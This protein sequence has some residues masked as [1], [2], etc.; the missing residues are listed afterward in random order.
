[1][2]IN[3][4]CST[5]QKYGDL[6]QRDNLRQLQTD[7][8]YSFD[9]AEYKVKIAEKDFYLLPSPHDNSK[10]EREVRNETGYLM[11]LSKQ[12]DVDAD[13]DDN[14]FDSPSEGRAQNVDKVADLPL[15]LESM[16]KAGKMKKSVS[17]SCTGAGGMEAAMQSPKKKNNNKKRK[18]NKGKQPQDGKSHDSIFFL[19][20]NLFKVKQ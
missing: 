16:N 1:M 2:H 12:D 11:N 10:E 3:K 15:K 20:L 14:N 5:I 4:K 9:P 6:T 8:E 18:K 17:L 7:I 19:D 13:G